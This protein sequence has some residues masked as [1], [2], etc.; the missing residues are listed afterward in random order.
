[1][2]ELSFQERKVSSNMA[3]YMKRVQFHKVTIT[4]KSLLPGTVVLPP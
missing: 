2:W 3:S 1:M 4:N